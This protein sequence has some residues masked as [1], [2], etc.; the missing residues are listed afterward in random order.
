MDI[1]ISPFPFKPPGIPGPAW[2][3]TFLIAA[4]SFAWKQFGYRLRWLQWHSDRI[5]GKGEGRG[6]G[7]HEVIHGTPWVPRVYHRPCVGTRTRV[8]GALGTG[9]SWVVPFRWRVH[10]THLSLLYPSVAPSLRTLLNIATREISFRYVPS[11]VYPRATPFPLSPFP[12]P[13]ST[14]LALLARRED[15]LRRNAR[16]VAPPVRSSWERVA[17]RAEKSR[18]LRRYLSRERE[19]LICDEYPFGLYR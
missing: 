2:S 4:R 5:W 19:F 15:A 6:G 14:P 18:C 12:P 1:S 10:N 13:P 8:S 3:D 17:S 11:P 7:I 16:S 9:P